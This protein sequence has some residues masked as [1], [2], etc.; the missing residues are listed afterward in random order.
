MQRQIDVYVWCV[1][2]DGA[3]LLSRA[4]T[5]R[6]WQ[7]PGGALGH[8]EN[9]ATA[10]RRTVHD[11]TGLTVRV[12]ALRGAE[13]EIDTTSHH[14][15][16][17]FD[18]IAPD[19]EGASRLAAGWFPLEDLAT[20]PLTPVVRRLAGLDPPRPL[21]EGAIPDG[22]LTGFPPHRPARAQRFGA[23]GLVTDPRGRVLLSLIAR[24]YPS[25]GRWHLPGGGT[26]PGEQPA[27]GLVRE[28]FEETGQRGRITG[29]VGVSHRHNPAAMGPEGYPIDWHTVRVMYRVTVDQPTTPMVTE[30]AGGS[31][32]RAAWFTQAELRKIPLT[33]VA[34]ELARRNEPPVTAET[35]P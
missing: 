15:I 5:D 26:D 16:L 32:A 30:A 10:A 14:D 18:A 9:P 2:D 33:E 35:R 20:L 11:S 8:G 27:D 25:A 7:L 21:T 3:V 12:G 29:L 31:T 17:I 22:H 19:G 1:R 28:I 24:G 34:S 13:A 6:P 23:Y 4:G